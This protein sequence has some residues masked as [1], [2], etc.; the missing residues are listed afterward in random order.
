MKALLLD[1]GNTRLQAVRLQY[2]VT[3][4]REFFND[5]SRHFQLRRSHQMD[6]DIAKQLQQPGQ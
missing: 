5:R 3:A 4:G 1:V 6:F 2:L